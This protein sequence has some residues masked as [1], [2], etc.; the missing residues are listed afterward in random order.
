MLAV[1]DHQQHRPRGQELGQALLQ[2]S[3][4]VGSHSNRGSHRV[5]NELLVGQR[6]HVGPPH[7]V[8]EKGGLAARGLEGEP[9]LS[10]PARPHERDEPVLTQE[11]R[12]VGQLVLASDE[13]RERFRQVVGLPPG[14]RQHRTARRSLA[15][16]SASCTGNVCGGWGELRLE[17]SRLDRRVEDVAAAWHGLHQS[18]PIV[19]E[20][21]S[22]L[23]DAL[24]QGIVRDE[25]VRPDRAGEILFADQPTVSLDEEHEDSEGLASELHFPASA[26]QAPAVEVEHDLARG[27]RAMGACQ[28]SGTPTWSKEL[29]SVAGSSRS[30]ARQPAASYR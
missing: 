7:T 4:A 19:I 13:A 6:S 18:M 1:V 17:P 24:G 8:A 30:V 10:A 16:R 29:H 25:R 23:R 20:R 3:G 5:G 26:Q 27:V 22:N 11:R 28:H 12:H 15:F 2:G 14:K 21:L 9:C